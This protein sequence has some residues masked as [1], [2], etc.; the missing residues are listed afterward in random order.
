MS[1]RFEEVSK[2]YGMQLIVENLSLEVR[3]SELFVL[4]GA[5]GS[6]KSTMLRM[7]AGLTAV[8]SGRILF[9]DK[10][11]TRQRPQERGVGF[12]FQHYSIF[13]HMDVAQNI[14]FGLKIRK[15]PA[16]ERREKRDKLLDLVGLAGLGARYASELSGGQQQR[17]ALARALAYEPQ[18]L[19]LDEPFGALDVK[20]RSQLRRSL[21]EIQR[22]LRVTTILVTHDQDEAFE[23]ADRIG[24]LER[25]RLVE[26]GPAE[27]M[28]SK[29]KSLHAAIFLG[30]GTV[31]VG[32]AQNGKAI[33]GPLSLPIPDDLPHEEG[34]KVQVLFRPEDVNILEAPPPAERSLG[35][36]VV[37]EQNFMGALRRVR[38]RLPQLPGTRQIAPSV[39][40][41][42]EGLVVDAAVGSKMPPDKNEYWVSLQSYHVLEQVGPR[43]LVIDNDRAPFVLRIAG[44]L[45]DRLEGSST[46]LS[47]VKDAREEEL[48][49]K[50]LATRQQQ[51]GLENAE[52]TIRTGSVP[53]QIL[54]EQN[55]GLYSL[56]VLAPPP[57]KGVAGNMLE[58]RTQL[59]SL[60][61]LGG[62]VRRVLQHVIV[63]TLILK[64]DRPAF[65]R[66]LICTAVGEPGKN[67]VRVGG[68][69][70]RRLGASVTL[71][72]VAQGSGGPK[73]LVRAHL[74]SAASTV[75]ALEVP[76]EIRVRQAES[77][78]EGILSESRES[79]CDLIVIGNHGPSRSIF[80]SSDVT[81]QVLL[82]ADRPVLIVPEGESF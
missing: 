32:S 71:L 79:D 59:R 77:P 26:V 21:K 55:T 51:S 14:E 20:I 47:I 50:D 49:R 33:L 3:D 38:L 81:L 28:Y 68:R 5:S 64:S 19:L 56:V 60:R 54:M 42:E 8:D 82:G 66:L 58:R 52:I 1:I 40:F 67:D 10:D 37:I 57:R 74:E 23:L 69:L 18:V 12:V 78:S 17:V 63:P 43:V 16:A 45:V 9:H 6:G 11:V 4:L 36:G 75:R 65:T 44:Q 35:L 25:G 24:L 76:V 39:P 62:T 46:L 2:R 61:K 30:A 73:G 80:G 72:Y 31:L 41:G 22:N 7:A 34:A 29:P 27:S 70:A 48:V 13:N 15:V 53:E